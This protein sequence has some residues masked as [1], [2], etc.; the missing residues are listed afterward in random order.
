M[1]DNFGVYFGCVLEHDCGLPRNMRDCEKPMFSLINFMIFRVRDLI[2]GANID[3]KTHLESDLGS[4]EF[5]C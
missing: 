3:R 2:F 5:V 1:L 4:E